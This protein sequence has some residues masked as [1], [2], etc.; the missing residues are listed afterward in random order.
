MT[1]TVK[2]AYI[3]SG[4]V[5]VN[6]KDVG[7]ASGVEISIEQ[8]TKSLPNYR[9]GGGNYAS[10]TKVTAVNLKMTLNKFSNENLA[11]ALRGAVSVLTAAAVTDEPITAMVDG[12]ADT[13][14][15]IDVSQ[16][17]TV[18]DSTGTTT[19]VAD[20]D[21]VAS[22]AGIR[23]LSGGDIADEDQLLVSYTSLAGNALEA[24]TESGVSVPVV[25]DG[26]NDDNGK[27]CVLK[28]Y[29]WKP[30]PTASLSIITDDYAS[31]DIEGEVLA[32]DTKVA[33]GVSKFFKRMAA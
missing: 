30:S 33:V 21:Y 11:M 28:F 3:G 2:E 8:E 20:E 17:V 25:V 18:K 16:T 4:I 29:L 1:T 10:T 31:F 9:G 22:A 26:L 6:G 32:D 23:V 14:K 27:P 15:L 5:Y 24:L 7:N 12:L 19:Y 13:T